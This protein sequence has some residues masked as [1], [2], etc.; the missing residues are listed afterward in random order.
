MEK[1][2]PI[3]SICTL[4]GKN[5][6]IMITGFY[7][8]EFNGNLKI[9]DY[10]GC[11]YPEGLLLP[12]LSCT[13]N[14]DD[15]ESVDFVGFKNEDYEKFNNM[16]KGLNSNEEKEE[17]S[18]KSSDGWI[19]ASNK[20]YS[21]L[22]FD[23]NGVVVLAEP[24]EETENKNEYKFDANG[25]VVKDLTN[26]DN[27]FHKTYD[28][29]KPK[30]MEEPTKIFGDYSFD[31]NGVVTQVNKKTTKVS[32]DSLNEIE[33]DENGVVISIKGEDLKNDTPNE[34]YIFDENGAVVKVNSSIETK[35]EYEFD[36]NGMVIGI[37]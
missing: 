24:V 7:S 5:K 21:K 8:S 18:E 29:V 31:E 3:G 23:E 17:N 16:L 13:F 2:L 32:S 10:S 11:A 30:E 12:E 14:H 15:I 6:K 19:L 33:F 4:K 35:K 28:A 1:Y 36:E 25:M 9:N 27:P 37:N 26:I 20:S 22:L 34:E